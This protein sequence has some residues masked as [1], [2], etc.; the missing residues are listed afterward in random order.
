MALESW[1]YRDP[2]EVAERRESQSCKGCAWL[3]EVHCFGRVFDRCQALPD[4][5]ELRRCRRYH[6][7]PQSR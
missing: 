5:T 6:A 1:E 4:R 3:V 7:L 2:L